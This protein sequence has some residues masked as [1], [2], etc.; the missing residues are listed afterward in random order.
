MSKRPFFVLF[1]VGMLA[2]FGPVQQSNAQQAITDSHRDLPNICALCH[3]VT[4]G[5]FGAA[6]DA[7][8]HTFLDD[9]EYLASDGV[10]GSVWRLCNTTL[11]EL[12][13]GSC[14]ETSKSGSCEQSH[15]E[16]TGGVTRADIFD[17][18]GRFYNSKRRH[19]NSL[20][21]SPLDIERT[22]AVP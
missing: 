20:Y 12:T 21:T 4:V 5:E 15:K 9:G 13:E 7:D 8:E 14:H 19:S 2:S 1:L 17:F 18:I 6:F 22:R 16:C 10:S 11:S 3:N